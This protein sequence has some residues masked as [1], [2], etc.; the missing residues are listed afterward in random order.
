MKVYLDA[1]CLNRPFDDQSQP[2][3]RLEVEAVSLILEKLNQGEWEWIGSEILLYELGQNPDVDN[4]QRTL[5]FASLAHQVVETT[6]KILTRAEELEEAGFD[7]YDAIHL[8]SAEFG[9]ADVFLT[10]DDQILKVAVRKKNL[11]SFVVEN[12]VKWMEEVL[13]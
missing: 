4:R 3:V 1:C 9:K 2:R 12:P 11:F 7:S 6:E 8:S 5:S 13:K 10:T